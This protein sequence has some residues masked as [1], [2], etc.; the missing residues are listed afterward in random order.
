[1]KG[2][3]YQFPFYNSLIPSRRSCKLS[4]DDDVIKPQVSFYSQHNTSLWLSVINS[5]CHLTWARRASSSSS[6]RQQESCA[7][8]ASSNQ[9]TKPLY[10]LS[11]FLLFTINFLF[12]PTDEN[13]QPKTQKLIWCCNEVFELL[14]SRER[15]K[16][17][18]NW[19]LWRDCWQFVGCWWQTSQKQKQELLNWNLI[20]VRNRQKSLLSQFHHSHMKA[21]LLFALTSW[22]TTTSTTTL[23]QQSSS[24][25]CNKASHITIKFHKSQ[26]CFGKNLQASWNGQNSKLKARLVTHFFVLKI[27]G[28]FDVVAVVIVIVARLV[29]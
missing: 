15:N 20:E 29:R 28:N 9:P 25:C 7:I 2:N 10:A 22:R 3:A 4:H 14:A 16:R 12:Q 18:Q 19:N 24:F 5:S 8:S 27:I 6:Q 26:M 1:M 11:D 13:E 23:L 21:K 17:S